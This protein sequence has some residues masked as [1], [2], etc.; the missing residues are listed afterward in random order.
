MNLPILSKIMLIALVAPLSCQRLQNEI[1]LDKLNLTESKDI[2]LNDLNEIEE[3]TTIQSISAE[4][5]T[6]TGKTYF[7]LL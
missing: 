1:E 3:L 6:V 7:D 4:D 2:N 5:V